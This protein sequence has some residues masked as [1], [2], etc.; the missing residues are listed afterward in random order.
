MIQKSP[1]STVSHR[2]VPFWRDVRAIRILSQIAFVILV[3]VVAGLL[4]SN[5]K[6]GLE[7]RGLG[8]GFDF[9]RLEAGFQI[10]EGITYDPSDSY[11]RAFVVGV[12]NTLRV[13][14]VGIILTTILG[15]VMGVA[16][17]STNWLVNKIAT[18]YVELIRNT[19]LLVQLFVWYFAIIL[20]LPRVKESIALPGSIFISNRGA[21]LPGPVPTA[22]FNSWLYYLMAAV[23]VAVALWI[24]RARGERRTGR[25]AFSLLWVGVAFIAL[26]I[27]G[28]FVVPGAPFVWDKP[29]LQGW[30]YQGGITLTP[31]FVAML[32]GLVVYTGAFI[33]EVVRAGIQAVPR[34][35]IEAARAVGLN[36]MHTL[37]LVIFPQALRVIVPPLTSQYLNLA[38][39]S[40]L[41]IA[42]GFPDLFNVAG[43]IFNQTGQ[44]VQVIALIMVSYLIMSLF[45]SLLMNLYNRRVQLVER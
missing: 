38:K 42:I 9:L 7:A 18:A 24:V 41:A 19:P 13:T 10:G 43:T 22:S 29:S 8:G 12:V 35:Q 45:T 33:A 44:A 31:E 21:A 27:L 15:V 20:K 5:M 2:A 37:R 39:N 1:V 17:L 40:S 4:Y 16:R 3:V 25:P 28:W 26:T 32:L 6:R 23:T 34:G 30:N 11:A 36:E 14:V